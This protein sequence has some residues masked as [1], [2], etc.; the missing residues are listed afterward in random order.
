MYGNIEQAFQRLMWS[1]SIQDGWI[2]LNA[3]SNSPCVAVS[4][5]AE[6]VCAVGLEF[7]DGSMCVTVLTLFARWC[8]QY[9]IHLGT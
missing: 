3:T 7:W 9:L 2:I 6:N 5:I 8:L 1:V 4:D